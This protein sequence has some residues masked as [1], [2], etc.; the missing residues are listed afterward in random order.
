MK[1]FRNFCVALAAVALPAL[2]G[3]GGGGSNLSSASAQD[4]TRGAVTFNLQFAASPLSSSGRAAPV[5]T[6]NKFGPPPLPA[7]AGNIPYGTN[8]VRV[9]VTDPNTGAELAPARL[10]LKPATTS[11]VA[12][13][14][15]V[16]YHALRVGPVKVDVSALPNHDGTGNALAVGSVTGQIVAQTT[17]TLTAPMTLTINH[18]TVS[19]DSH[20]FNP[21]ATSGD[22]TAS[23]LDS[24]GQPLEYILQFVSAD[25]DI[26]S[27]FPTGDSTAQVFAGRARGTTEVLVYEPNSGIST[28]VPVTNQ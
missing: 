25:P 5:H 4:A 9:V 28:T 23:A 16:Q 17:T 27:V 7:F 8:S 13:L 3:C 1:S 22:L 2:A 24:N 18:I 26:V 14:L 11:G 10:V 12:P 15:T 19:P 20:S 21:D 6:R